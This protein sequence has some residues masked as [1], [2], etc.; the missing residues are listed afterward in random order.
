[1]I[2]RTLQRLGLA[3]LPRPA[4]PSP[5]V[6]QPQ[7]EVTPPR[8]T[9]PKRHHPNLDATAIR[10]RKASMELDDKGLCFCCEDEADAWLCD[11]CAALGCGGGL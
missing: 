6:Y 4:Y 3:P 2:A 7:A 1:M 5:K 10:V 9:L 11:D 8:E